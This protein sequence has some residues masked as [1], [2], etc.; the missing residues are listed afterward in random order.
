VKKILIISIF[1]SFLLA[2]EYSIIFATYKNKDYAEKT[3]KNLKKILSH[4]INPNNLYIKKSGTYYEVLLKNIE[5]KKT[6]DSILK[7]TKKKYTDLIVQKNKSLKDAIRYYKNK[8]YDKAYKILN[9]R[10]L[11]NLDNIKLQYY[12]GRSA[13]KLGKF[14][15]A[16]S[17]YE[18]VLILKP[19][20][21]RAKLEMAKTYF[22]IKKFDK[23]KKLFT[24]ILKEKIPPQVKRNVKKYL[25]AIEKSRKKSFLKAVAITGITYDSNVNNSP[26]DDQY[27]VPKLQTNLPNGVTDDSDYAHQEILMLNHLYDIGNP[28]DFIVKNN[29]LFFF[30]TMKKYSDKNV[31]FYSYSPALSYRQNRYLID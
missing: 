20:N 4:E 22:K 25:T 24:E 21:I 13:Y 3:L 15:E 28:G 5:N 6:L 9:N 1:C 26:V 11:K 2:G 12:L 18:R 29:F 31:F 14:E 7:K 16:I 19:D 10:F 27:Y 8:E 17:A 30:K 23:S